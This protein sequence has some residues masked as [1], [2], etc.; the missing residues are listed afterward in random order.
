[1]LGDK[2]TTTKPHAEVQAQ[3]WTHYLLAV[4]RLN[5]FSR[6]VSSAFLYLSEVSLVRSLNEQL[7]NYTP[8][9]QKQR[10]DELG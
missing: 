2:E 9:V 5:M 4:R 7:N 10:L 8:E 1:M 6:A 3:N